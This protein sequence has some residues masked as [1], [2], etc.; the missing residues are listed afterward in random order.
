[1]NVSLDELSH[2]MASVGGIAPVDRELVEKTALQLILTHVGLKIMEAG[3]DANGG[4]VASLAAQFTSLWMFERDRVVKLIPVKEGG[5][6]K[7]H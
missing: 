1:M 4:N 2:R 7:M 3:A 5:E 6:D